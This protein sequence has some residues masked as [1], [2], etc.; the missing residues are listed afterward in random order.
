MKK[1]DSRRGC[2]LF[3]LS[4]YETSAR[5]FFGELRRRQADLLLDI[6]LRNT[7][8]LCGFT[9]EKDLAYLVSALTGARYLHDLRFAPSPELLQAYQKKQLDFEGYRQGYA[10]EMAERQSCAYFWK[11]YGGYAHICLL[12]TATRKRRSH[13]EVLLELLQRENG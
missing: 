12:G 2:E 1:D 10:Q 13:S 3:T 6:R 5:E 9:K 4:A 11:Q 8:Q 7:S